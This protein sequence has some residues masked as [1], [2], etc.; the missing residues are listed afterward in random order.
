MDR[1]TKNGKNVGRYRLDGI[2]ITHLGKT[3]PRIPN[4]DM[5]KFNKAAGRVGGGLSTTILP[6]AQ[7]VFEYWAE[8]ALAKGNE[9]S[10]PSD[11]QS[12]IENTGNGN[13]DCPLAGYG[14][15]RTKTV[16]TYRWSGYTVNKQYPSGSEDCFQCPGTYQ[17]I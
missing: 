8:E 3:P 16:C 11:T 6:D 14:Q 7:E 13:V 2:P 4:S 5:K 12:S 1:Y 9:D 15:S 10:S 17:R